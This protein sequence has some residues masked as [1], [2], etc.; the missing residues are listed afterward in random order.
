MSSLQKFV[1]FLHEYERSQQNETVYRCKHPRCSHYQQRHL[2]VG[3]EASC[4]KCHNTFILTW[5]ALRRK[6]PV[7]DYCTKSPKAAQLRALRDA[8][9]KAVDP[10]FE[11][12]EEITKLLIDKTLE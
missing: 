1:H 2:L 5:R 3:K 7:C 4:G 9:V 10:E 6:T 11:L 12:N 8:T